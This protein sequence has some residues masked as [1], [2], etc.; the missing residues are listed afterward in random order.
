MRPEL[1]SL[2]RGTV[3]P[4]AV[5]QV[6]CG[7]QTPREACLEGAAQS[8]PGGEGSLLEPRTGRACLGCCSA[9]G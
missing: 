8:A 4:L 7:R 2:G 6:Q 9:R 3:G 5:L 1:W